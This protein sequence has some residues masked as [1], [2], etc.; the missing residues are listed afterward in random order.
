MSTMSILCSHHANQFA[1]KKPGGLC[2]N[3]SASTVALFGLAPHRDSLRRAYS[4]IVYRNSSGCG[5]LTY[6]EIFRAAAIVT[7]EL[8][9]AQRSFAH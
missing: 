6:V 1:L 8:R 5:L 9:Q 3:K 2:S 7:I 4:I